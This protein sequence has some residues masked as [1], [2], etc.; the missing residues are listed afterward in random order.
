MS[1]EKDWL[2]REMEKLERDRG[3]WGGRAEA[4][5]AGLGSLGPKGGQPQTK[6]WEVWGEHSLPRDQPQRGGDPHP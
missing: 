3:C 5:R 2:E 1:S 4:V 6:A